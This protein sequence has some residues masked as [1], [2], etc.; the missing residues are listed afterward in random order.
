MTTADSPF[1]YLMLDVTRLLRKHFD[2][3]AAPL[4]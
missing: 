2:R 1:A 4:G 3:R